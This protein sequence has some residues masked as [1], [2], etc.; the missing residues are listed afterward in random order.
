MT[1]STPNV[2]ATTPMAKPASDIKV[3]TPDLIILDDQSISIEVMTDL[4][5][6]NIGGQELI[7]ISRNDIV[8]G[9]NILYQPIK[10]ITSLAF[11]YSPQ[12]LIALQD[13]DKTYFS[14]FPINIFYHIP[15]T[16]SGPNGESI[17][18]DQNTGNLVIDVIN[19]KK[20]Y[21]VEV[22]ISSSLTRIDDTIYGVQ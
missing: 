5:F 3:A 12:N 22:Q 8:N 13:T 10:N 20:D 21:Q 7:E 6:E 17:Y 18:I 16:G 11:Q 15:D 14:G 4:I 9:Q 2:P 19:M 1:S